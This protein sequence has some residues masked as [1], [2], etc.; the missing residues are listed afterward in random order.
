MCGVWGERP[1]GL[2]PDAE[3]VRALLPDL[4]AALPHT[5][6]PHWGKVTTMDPAEVTARFPRWDDFAALR[7]RYDPE[8]RFVNEYLERLGL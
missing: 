4:E 3:G 1:P 2:P 7:A 8:R 6:R 5:A